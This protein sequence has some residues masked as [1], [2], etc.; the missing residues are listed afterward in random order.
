M[1]MYKSLGFR[2][3]HG[4]LLTWSTQERHEH[5][6]MIR[7]IQEASME[8]LEQKKL[9]IVLNDFVNECRS[10][11]NEMLSDVRL[12]GSYARGDYNDDSDIDLMV[13]L[14]MNDAG[15]RKS[16]HDIC[17]VAA[18]LELK[19]GVTISP[20]LYGKEEYASRKS[21]GFCKKVEM[22]GVSQ[23]VGQIYA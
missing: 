15:V 23:C 19:H 14:D 8:V 1:K 11:F 2:I 5:G 13:I 17:R 10:V 20:V 6:A 21:F 18:M 4:S 22:E 9:N 7:E 12:F 3:P 16:R